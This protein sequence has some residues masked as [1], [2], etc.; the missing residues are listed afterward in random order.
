MRKSGAYTTIALPPFP[1]DVQKSEK[2]STQQ[3]E[4]LLNYDRNESDPFKSLVA[5][6]ELLSPLEKDLRVL[7]L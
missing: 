1:K 5:E 6:F 7:L 4:I 3:D 2:Q